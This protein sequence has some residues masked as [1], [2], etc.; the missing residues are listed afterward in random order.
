VHRAALLALEGD[1]GAR[2]LLERARVTEV[3]VN[4]P[5]VLQDI[6]LASDL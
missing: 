1:Q 2:K 4:D 5:G 6:D 3:A